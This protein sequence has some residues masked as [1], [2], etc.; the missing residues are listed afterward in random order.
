MHISIGVRALRFLF[1]YLFEYLAASAVI[2]IS[3]RKGGD[4]LKPTGEQA[5]IG[6]LRENIRIPHIQKVETL[7]LVILVLI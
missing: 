3:W 2:E 5:G 4:C 7:I 1:L 6:L